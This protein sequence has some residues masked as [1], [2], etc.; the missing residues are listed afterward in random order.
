MRLHRGVSCPFA[1]RFVIPSNRRS[2]AVAALLAA[3]LFASHASAAMLT[4]PEAAATWV[5]RNRAFLAVSQDLARNGANLLPAQ[6]AACRGLIGEHLRI[7]GIT[8][9]WATGAQ[10]DFCRAMDGFNGKASVKNPCGD[11]RSAARQYGKAVPFGDSEAVTETS[12]QMVGLIEIILRA[13]SQT[14]KC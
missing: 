13:A 5:A 11:L 7:G 6:Q 4:K 10:R 9:H 1:S 8:P 3:G 12:R 2:A 14:H